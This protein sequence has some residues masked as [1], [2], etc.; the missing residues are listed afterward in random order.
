MFE[1]SLSQKFS[2]DEN[3]WTG[4]CAGWNPCCSALMLKGNYSDEKGLTPVPIPSAGLQRGLPKQNK[5]QK[6]KTNKQTKLPQQIQVV[7]GD[8]YRIYP[9]FQECIGIATLAQVT[10]Q[11]SAGI[12]PSHTRWKQDK[13]QGEGHHMTAGRSQRAESLQSQALSLGSALAPQ[14]PQW[15]FAAQ[16]LPGTPSFAWPLSLQLLRK[17]WQEAGL[18]F[19]SPSL[20]TLHLQTICKENPFHLIKKTQETIF[21]TNKETE[22]KL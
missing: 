2:D 14:S 17:F 12:W 8:I 21:Q 11:L 15:C 13:C 18:L 3:S 4:D 5:N 9:Q 16:P 6:H 7:A 20:P 10:R 1:F 22:I 19:T